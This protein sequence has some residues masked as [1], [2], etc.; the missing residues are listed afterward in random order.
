MLNDLIPE[1]A[2]SGYEWGDA[3]LK[4]AADVGNGFPQSQ[5]PK[6]DN[7]QIENLGAVQVAI[8]ITQ[9][10]QESSPYQTTE[11]AASPVCN[12]LHHAHVPKISPIGSDN[13]VRNEDNLDILQQKRPLLRKKSGELVKPALKPSS[14]RRRPSSIP[15]TPMSSKVVRFDSHLEHI[16]PF[17][18][19]DRP[20]AVSSNPSSFK[21][22]DI[23]TEVPFS[24][25]R[26]H[27]GQNMS[28]EWEA[29]SSNFPTET[30][31][32]LSLPVRVER[33]YL[34]SDIM[35]LIGIVAVKNLAYRKVVTAR[36]TLDHWKTSSD[37]VAEFNSHLRQAKHTDGYDRFNFK[38]KLASQANLEVKT[39]LLAVK[40][41]V[42]G[43]EYWDNN[44][45]ANFQIV[46][47]KKPKSRNKE[48]LATEKQQE[49]ASR[50]PFWGE[51]EVRVDTCRSR[52]L[53]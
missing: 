17:L 32:R 8:R 50:P 1:L 39:L 40:Y 21:T 28:L 35:E 25:D 14:A 22:Y 12:S 3:S 5:T 30:P 20:L 41:C 16:R 46:F 6:A 33:V 23:A 42:N 52:L 51:G 31:K 43:Q 53:R 44:S 15:I 27:D 48:H 49:F 37:V 45:S 7:S 36:Y 11:G 24:D 29:I 34:S 4:D 13:D 18:Q 9:R 47:R 19:V 38:I 10:C 26:F 2:N